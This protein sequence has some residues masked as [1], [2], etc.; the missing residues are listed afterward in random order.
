MACNKQVKSLKNE[1]SNFKKYHLRQYKKFRMIKVKDKMNLDTCKRME[2]WQRFAES[3]TKCCQDS[4]HVNEPK[5]V[6]S[7]FAYFLPNTHV[8]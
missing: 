3:V 8:T 7:E 2:R 1:V 5:A 4:R 6:V